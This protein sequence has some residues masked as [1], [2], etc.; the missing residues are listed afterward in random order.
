MNLFILCIRGDLWNIR[1]QTHLEFFP[2]FAAHIHHPA[3]H[4][5]RLPGIRRVTPIFPRRSLQADLRLLPFDDR[6]Q[7]FTLPLGGIP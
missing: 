2:A 5:D 6:H 7:P 4:T 1:Y 3:I